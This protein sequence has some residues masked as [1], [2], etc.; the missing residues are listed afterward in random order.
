[1][2]GAGTIM[3]ANSTIKGLTT[4]ASLWSVACIGLAIGA[5]YYDLGVMTAVL[6][7]IVLSLLNYV[8]KHLE[9][10][11]SPK[12]IVINARPD[13]DVVIH[14]LKA[15]NSAGVDTQETETRFYYKGE[16]N[17]A[18]ITFITENFKQSEAVLKALKA[19]EGIT[20]IRL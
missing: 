16:D 4:A 18:E 1:F 6:V 19:V 3:H 9:K 13:A 12:Q 7:L 5:G 17:S 2:L 20:E 14:I 10:N 15:I 11:S 8:T